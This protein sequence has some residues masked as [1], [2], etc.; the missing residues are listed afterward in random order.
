MVPKLSISTSGAGVVVYQDDIDKTQ[1]HYFPKGAK[2][3]LGE[4]LLEFSVK[5]WGIGSEFLIQDENGIIRSS[6]GAILSGRASIDLSQWQRINIIEIISRDFNI[7]NPKLTPLILTDVKVQPVFAENTLNFGENSDKIF[8]ETV[9]L[10]SSFNY[11][12]ATGNNQFGLFVGTMIEGTNIT[13]NSDFAINVYG[14]AEFI[15]DPWT[16]TIKADLS[17]VW[18]YTRRQFGAS[19]GYKW[20]KID[21]VKYSRIV[22]DL[23]SK[24]IV[25]LNFKEGSFDNEQY[26]RQIFDMGRQ[27]FEAIN[28]QIGSQIGFFRF[29]PNPQPEGKLHSPRSIPFVPHINLSYGEQS[30]K[31]SQKT[32]FDLTISYTG[33]VKISE[34]TSITLAVKCN[35]ATKQ[36]FQ[37]LGDPERPCIDAQKVEEMNRR[38]AAEKAEKDLMLKELNDKLSEKQDD[39]L[40]RLLNGEITEEQYNKAIE[41]VTEQHRKALESLYGVTANEDRRFIVSPVF[42]RESIIKFSYR[43]IMNQLE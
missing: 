35:E 27:I 6:T 15:G 2:L 22:Q 34:G 13:P 11:L 29:E 17:R 18:S 20:F 36:Y 9:Q 26:G 41:I 12:L 8:P 10:A 38:L 5:Y 31:S 39:L 16:V 1:F 24:Q 40:N 23:V 28:T 4:N 21:S 30:I 43:Q 19:V 32:Q 42:S 33:R 3:N 14:K 7:K 37:D 25:T